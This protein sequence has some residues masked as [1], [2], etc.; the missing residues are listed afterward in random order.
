VMFKGAVVSIHISEIAGGTMIAKPEVTAV[1]GRGLEGDRY[2]ANQGH[3]SW[4]RGPLREISFI[5]QE[6]IL[7]AESDF[8][9]KVASGETRR[10]II[11]RGVPLS[12]LVG[13]VF[14][15]GGALIRGVEIATPCRR[16]CEVTGQ[17][18]FL[19]A[20]MHRG[21]LHAAVVADGI[22]RVGDPVEH[23]STT[24][25]LSILE[26]ESEFRLAHNGF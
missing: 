7:Q 17:D 13:K 1:C 16:L 8:R 25:P 2:Y 26:T 5:E 21:G 9:I 3:F 24:N 23:H 12:H 6:S 15:V 22:I 20:F 10:N 14:R 11:T 4:F 18:K 19:K